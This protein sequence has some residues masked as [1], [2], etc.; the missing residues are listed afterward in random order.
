[1]PRQPA[2]VAASATLR[3]LVH[4]RE[5]LLQGYAHVMRRVGISHPTRQAENARRARLR[6]QYR[7]DLRVN[8]ERIA[9]EVSLLYGHPLKTTVYTPDTATG[10]IFHPEVTR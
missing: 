8:A 1:M 2:T 5:R 4:E 7:H 10:D 9:V 3:Q 6:K